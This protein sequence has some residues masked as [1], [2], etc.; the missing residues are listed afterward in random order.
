MTEIRMRPRN[1]VVKDRPDPETDRVVTLPSAAPKRRGY[2]GRL[3]GA[4]ALLLLAC[5]LAL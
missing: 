1:E 4:S 3:F 5:S 2:G